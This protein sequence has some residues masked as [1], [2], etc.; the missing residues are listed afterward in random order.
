M[1]NKLIGTGIT[2]PIKINVLGGVDVV[3]G[4][5]LIQSS[6]KTILYWPKGQR[7][8]NEQFVSKIFKV[9]E[10]PNDIVS[11]ALVRHYVFETLNMWEKRIT[12]TDAKVL[13]SSNESVT[14]QIKYIIR[15]TR[16][17]ETMV[18]PYYKKIIY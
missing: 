3:G 17:E 6:I 10:E 11:K 13:S 9:L 4:S 2:F 18:F 5:E 7:F 1:D 12:A 16:I 14:I 15:S 8:F